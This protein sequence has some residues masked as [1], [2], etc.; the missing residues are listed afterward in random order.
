MREAIGGSLLLSIVVVFVSLIILFFVGILSYTKAYKVK[1]KIIDVIERY[2]TYNTSEV[3]NEI[4]TTLGDMGYQLGDCKNNANNLNESGYKYCV[5]EVC[6]GTTNSDGSCE[7]AHYYKV[8]TYIQFYFPIIGELFNP[9]VHG[10][11]R[12]L[13]KNYDY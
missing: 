5:Y 13:G 2:E 1:N 7:G 9:P 6:E 8:T 12:I 4:E 3:E 11:T 10:E